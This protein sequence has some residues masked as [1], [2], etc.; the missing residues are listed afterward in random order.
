MPKVIYTK[1]LCPQGLLDDLIWEALPEGGYLSPELD[2]SV[3]DRYLTIGSFVSPQVAQVIADNTDNLPEIQ[4]QK[5]GEDTP[6]KFEEKQVTKPASKASVSK[7][8]P[9]KKAGS[10]SKIKASANNNASTET[11]PASTETPSERKARL[12]QEAGQN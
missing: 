12:E 2:Q 1:K 3:V 10:D 11:P 4:E 8:T 5:L 6:P 9:A 7:K